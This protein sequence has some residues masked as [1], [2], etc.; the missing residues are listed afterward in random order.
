MYTLVPD[1]HTKGKGYEPHSVKRSFLFLFG[2][3]FPPLLPQWA[4][5]HF[6][7]PSEDKSHLPE[8]I[9]KEQNISKKQYNTVVD[10]YTRN[11]ALGKKIYVFLSSFYKTRLITLQRL[12]EGGAMSRGGCFYGSI[13][14]WNH[15]LVAFPINKVYLYS[16]EED[17]YQTNFIKEN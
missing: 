1:D 3:E 17:L 16:G 5:E 2:H 4:T 14:C 7:L 6:Q 10:H 15:Y 12:L 11:T 9:Q 8:N 13:P